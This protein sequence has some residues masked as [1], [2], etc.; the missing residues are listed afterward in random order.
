MRIFALRYMR[1]FSYGAVLAL[2]ASAGL[3]VPAPQDVTL[4]LAGYLVQRGVMTPAITVPVC[5]VG[6][7]TG[8]AIGF[9]L[10][11]KG[12]GQLRRLP[13]V[14]AILTSERFARA[15]TALARH[16]ALTIAVGRNV[17]GVRTAIFATAAATG[18]P[19]GRFLLWDVLAA[20][21]NVALLLSLGYGFSNNLKAI[22]G[23]VS[24]AERWIALGSVG[25]AFAWVVMSWRRRRRLAA[26][27]D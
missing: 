14:G 9:W 26:G 24:R 11:R 21:P 5:V 3:G 1:Q 16:E 22:I 17:A 13:R 25:L 19:F 4:L 10:V 2:L 12:A 20:I 8:D 27:A 7:V 15:Q 18:T 6:A 23:Q